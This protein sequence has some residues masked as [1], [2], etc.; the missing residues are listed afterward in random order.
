MY[1]SGRL[2]ARRKLYKP[3]LRA[4]NERFYRLHLREYFMGSIASILVFF[5][6]AL[7]LMSWV[8]LI[9][10]SFKTDYAWGFMSIFMPPLAYLYSMFNLGKTWQVLVLAF[11]GSGMLI[12]GLV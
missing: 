7:L 3:L 8:Y 6:A 5:G 9:I 10:I 2:P 11:V 4:Y 12:A 1:I